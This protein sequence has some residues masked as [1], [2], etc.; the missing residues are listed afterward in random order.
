[1]ATGG[2][3]FKRGH[4]GLLKTR[5]GLAFARPWRAFLLSICR[6]RGAGE[7]SKE[8]KEK[9]R[10]SSRWPRGGRGT[11]PWPS[12]RSALRSKDVKFYPQLNG[13]KFSGFFVLY[14]EPQK[15]LV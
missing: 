12:L 7:N 14:E 3:E 5:P 8:N 2:G 9:A 10:A 15:E 6:P 4:L 1:M 11:W 13:G